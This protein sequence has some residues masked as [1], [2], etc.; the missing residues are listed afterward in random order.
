MKAGG[1]TQ[2]LARQ[3]PEDQGP[4]VKDQGSRLEAQESRIK[5]RIKDQRSRI[6]DQ[7]PCFGTN[8]HPR[9]DTDVILRQS[10]AFF[11]VFNFI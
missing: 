4:R 11:E 8:G 10:K 7:G 9:R 3:D 2:M 6:K 5:G 1:R